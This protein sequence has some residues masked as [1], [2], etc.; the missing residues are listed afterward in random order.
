MASEHGIDDLA[1]RRGFGKIQILKRRFR[2]PRERM[3]RRPFRVGRRHGDQA[4]CTD[5]HGL[6]QRLIKSEVGI[7]MGDA[8]HEMA[9]TLGQ[10]PG[11]G[12]HV[13]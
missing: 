7:G 8:K 3:E 1:E 9:Q 2:R 6:E 5:D 13:V 10:I 4:V 11:T 12:I